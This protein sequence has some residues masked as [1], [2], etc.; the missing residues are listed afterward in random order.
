MLDV[1]GVLLVAPA[2]TGVGFKSVHPI[3]FMGEKLAPKQ[4]S[5]VEPRIRSSSSL[6]EK[7]DLLPFSHSRQRVCQLLSESNLSS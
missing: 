6:S 4:D 3:V 2:F 7:Q 5:K 1:R